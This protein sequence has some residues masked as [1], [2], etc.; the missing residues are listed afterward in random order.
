[1]TP[2]EL[3]TTLFSITN[4]SITISDLRAALFTF[5]DQD[6]PLTTQALGALIAF[7][8]AKAKE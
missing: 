6:A 7:E 2:R 8:A 3:R 5:Q 4:Q 1:M